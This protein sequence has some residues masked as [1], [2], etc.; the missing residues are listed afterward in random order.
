MIT[1]PVAVNIPVFKWQAELWWWNHQKT[2]GENA[3]NKGCL[4]VIDK[5]HRHETSLTN[6]WYQNIPHY[7]ATGVWS[8]LPDTSVNSLYMPLNIQFGLRQLLDKFSDSEVLEITDCD[9]FH[10]RQHPVIDLPEESIFVCDLYENWHMFTLSKN[11]NVIEPYFKNNGKYYNGGFVPIIGHAK[12]FKKI[13][14]DWENIHRDILSK[15]F[16]DNIKWWAGMFAL[17]AACE[18]NQIQMIAKDWCFIPPANSLSQTHYIYH[19]SVDK[20]FNKRNYPNIDT[21]LFPN[22]DCYDRIAQ[23]L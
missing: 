22:N 9:L 20:I 14:E 16:S 23:C 21:S 8:T 18:Q 7:E 4:L 11:K 3:R 6:Y 2:Y 17:S 15:N 5:N 13:I 19:Y 1:I 12:T 10:F